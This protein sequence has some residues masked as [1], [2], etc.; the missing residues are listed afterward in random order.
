MQKL[1]NFMKL[2]EKPKFFR[3]LQRWMSVT[4]GSQSLVGN[5]VTHSVWAV[6]IDGQEILDRQERGDSQ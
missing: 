3:D 5:Q 6:I 4:S 1:Q 2:S